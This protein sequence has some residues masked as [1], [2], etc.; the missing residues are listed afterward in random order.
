MQDLRGNTSDSRKYFG[1]YLAALAIPSVKTNAR[2]VTY[3]SGRACPS[4]RILNQT[5]IFS[6]SLRLAGCFLFTSAP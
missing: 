6:F 1:D 3:A 4:Y 2:R 5:D